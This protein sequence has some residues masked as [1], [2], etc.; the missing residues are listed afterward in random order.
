MFTLIFAPLTIQWSEWTRVHP[1]P[2]Q[3]AFSLKMRLRPRLV[4]R[5][6][7]L[8]LGTEGA[9]FQSELSSFL[10]VKHC[11]LVNPVGGQLNCYFNFTSSKLHPTDVLNLA[12][13]SSLLLPVFPPL[14]L[15]FVRL[16]QM[17]IDADPIT[18]NAIC[19]QLESA[20]V[21]VKL[22]VMLAHALGN[23]FDIYTTLSFCRKY[24]LWS[25][26]LL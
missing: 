26:R 6:F 4:L 9:S 22:A 24:N 10:G 8:T 23:P 17:F 7:W 25:L 15:Q 1:Y 11:L 18:G 20:F 16:V 3:V 12:T 2:M 13:K 14:L 19:D 5:R 21:L